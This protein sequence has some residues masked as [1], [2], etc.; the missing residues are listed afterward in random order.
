MSLEE[1]NLGL[2]TTEELVNE[3]IA[4]FT[5]NYIGSP[6]QLLAMDRIVI[7]AKFLGGLTALEKEYRTVDQ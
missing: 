2:A 3:L 7:L 6:E 1:A 5:I 4:R